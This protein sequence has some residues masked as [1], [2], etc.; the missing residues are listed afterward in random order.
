M[1]DRQSTRRWRAPSRCQ[2]GAAGD[3]GC[4]CSHDAAGRQELCGPKKMLP[5]RAV[6]FRRLA[7]R[8]EIHRIVLCRDPAG[9]REDRL[10]SCRKFRGDDSD[11]VGLRLDDR[12]PAALGAESIR[13]RLR[14]GRLADE[15]RGQPHA[16]CSR[17]WQDFDARFHFERAP[18]AGSCALRKPGPRDRQAGGRNARELRKFATVHRRTLS[19]GLVS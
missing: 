11:R 12:R 2:S 17:R 8:G 19:P 7:G 16:R 4:R 5:F 3:F 9:E 6:Y 18:T 10:H 15:R 14:E 1:C 13:E